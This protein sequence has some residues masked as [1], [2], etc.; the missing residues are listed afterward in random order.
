M[1]K[2]A[3]RFRSF[4]CGLLAFMLS[5]SLTLTMLIVGLKAS[6]LNP[7]FIIR[8]INKT[9]YAEKLSVELRDQLVSYGN[10]CNLD[11]SYF[12]TVFQNIITKEQIED[13]TAQGIR[14]F[15]N[16]TAKEVSTD[17]LEKALLEE[18][19]NYVVKKNYDL[20]SSTM[21][22]ITVISKEMGKI[23]S[24]YVGIFS[25]SYFVTASNLLVRYIKLFDYALI[26]LGVFSLL[27]IIV[28]RLSFN[29]AK[30]YLRYFIYAGSGSSLMLLVAPIVLLIMGIGNK[31]NIAN[32]SLYTMT[33]RLINSGIYTF[34][35]VGGVMVTVTVIISVIRVAVIKKG[36]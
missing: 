10:A 4:L 31:V 36:K 5:V 9:D 12:D 7:N 21:D 34:I 3:K 30:N 26:G 29:K 23:Y 14:N 19:K 15:Y 11:E 8:V 32:P 27:C 35:A 22:N 33:S 20:D 2:S 28:I 18:L 13:Y 17:E 16:G 1:T 24:A 6:A 25:S